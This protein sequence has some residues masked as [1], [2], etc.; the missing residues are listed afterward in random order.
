MAR[1]LRMGELRSLRESQGAEATA[2]VVVNA[3]NGI[4]PDG[5]ALAESD[6]ID[7]RDWSVRTLFESLVG[8]CSDFGAAGPSTRQFSEAVAS[9]AFPQITTALISQSVQAA[10]E[11]VPRISDQLHEIIPSNHPSETLVGHK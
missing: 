6:R 4:G 5:K 10:Y 2:R 7:Y 8:W 1:L 3:I 11:R 9:S